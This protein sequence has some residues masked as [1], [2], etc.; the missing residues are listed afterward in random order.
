MRSIATLRKGGLK[1]RPSLSG[2]AQ[3]PVRNAVIPSIAVFPLLQHSGS[4]AECL[5]SP[6]DRVREGTMIARAAGPIS[7]SV[8][9]SIPG[10]VTAH[11][12]I[13]LP[14]GEVSDAVTV[15]LE[16]GFERLGKQP[17]PEGEA[18]TR[19]VLLSTLY[20][21]GMVTLDTSAIP[22]HI[23]WKMPKGRHVET[24]IVSAIGD[25]PY[26]SV[27]PRLAADRTTALIEGAKLAFEVLK[28]RNVV[29][30]TEESETV[31]EAKPPIVQ[32]F[33]D[34]AAS[35]GLS[36]SRFVAGIRYPRGSQREL[37]RMATGREME[38]GAAP[39]S[40]GVMITNASTLV[41][42]RDVVYG[43]RSLIERYVT[44]AGDAIA[45]PAILRVRIGTRL[46]DVIEECGGF[47]KLPDQVVV[48]GPLTGSAVYDLDTPV[49]KNTQA[50]LALS[51][52]ESDGGRRLPCIECG[53]CVTSCP[54][55]LNPARLFK[56]I[57]HGHVDL[58]VDSGLLGCIECGSCSF[59]CP[60]NIAL[61]ETLRI[62]KSLSARNGR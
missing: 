3:G 21:A 24:L 2:L 44:V 56:Q 32:D 26:L 30:V 36:F 53:R 60:S 41:A 4:P 39:L 35:A 20:E 31:D 14:N 34:A 29:L 48:G 50:V 49:T 27:E 52:R 62:G 16:G 23:H 51:K 1:L 47:S 17:G 11:R 7:A 43:G 37:V 28:P 57:E 6:G 13:R 9:A 8:H 59:V 5:V 10:V 54:E 19:E 12:P 46:K 18:L 55:E 61:L 42:V 33:E 40:V 38:S 45:S 58:A 25:E 15:R 22:L